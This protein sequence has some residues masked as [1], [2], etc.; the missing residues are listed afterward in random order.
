VGWSS[1]WGLGLGAAAALLALLLAFRLLKVVGAG[2][3][4]LIRSTDLP[5]RSTLLRL[6][7][8]PN[9]PL[10]AGAIH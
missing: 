5:L 2:E 4:A 1:F 8:A 10:D 7:G 9:A 6:V 3:A